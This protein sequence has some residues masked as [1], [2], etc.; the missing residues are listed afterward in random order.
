MNDSGAGGA[1]AQTVRCAERAASRGGTEPLFPPGHPFAQLVRAS[2]TDLC[3]RVSPYDIN[4]LFNQ[5]ADPNDPRSAFRKDYG[6][7]LGPGMNLIMPTAGA[8]LCTPGANRVY[9]PEGTD[10]TLI[11]YLQSVGFLGEALIHKGVDEI[12]PMARRAGRPVYSIDD[13]GEG[14]DDITAN[15]LRNMQMVNSK[16]TVTLLSRFAAPEVRKD[17]FDVGDADFHAAWSPGHKVYIKTCNTENAGEGVF[18]VSS[19][20]EFRAEMEGIRERTRAYGLNP[21]VVIQPEVR[22]VN[23]SFQ[24]FLDKDEAAP[25]P[26]VALTDQ[27][28]AAD[29]KKYAGS[30]NHPVTAERLAV[31]APAILD[32]VR[33]IREHCPGSFGFVMCDYFERE[34]GSIVIYDPGLRPSSNT[35]AAMVKLWA[36]EATGQSVGVS[37][38]PWFDFGEPGIPYEEIARRLGDLAD[39]EHIADQ[40]LG[41]LPRGHNPI[42]GK[43]RFI[44]VTPEPDDYEEFRRE[45]EERIIRPELRRPA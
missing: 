11:T 36:E 8:Y 40:R 15:S 43:T 1:V 33:G 13:F 28:V 20:E 7:L 45:L 38:S 18:P 39:P 5:T 32:L 3:R 37:N 9:L 22:G 12:V 44:V 21:I 42:Q 6:A 26:V 14:A 23:K 10:R 17:M 35:G 25:I 2:Y 41:V 30:I 16:E 34:D 27:L 4:L 31:V 29:G 24:I 19:L